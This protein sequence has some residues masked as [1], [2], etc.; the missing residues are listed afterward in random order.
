MLLSKLIPILFFS[1]SGLKNR[2]LSVMKMSESDLNYEKKLILIRHG[3]THMNEYLERPGSRWGDPNFTDIFDAH[4]LDLYKDSMLSEKGIEQA[5][6]LHQFFHSEE[7]KLLLQDV[8][9]VAV[10]PLKRTLQT[11]EIGV[12]PHLINSQ[13]TKP[14][15][16]AQPLATERLYLVSDLGSSIESLRRLFPFVD[17]SSEFERFGDEWWFTVKEEVIERSDEKHKFSSIHVDDYEEWRPCEENQRYSCHGEPDI[18]FYDRMKALYEW[19]ED[20]EEKVIMLV[21]HWGV[22]GHLTDRDFKNCEVHTT[23][24]Q[25]IRTVLNSK[26]D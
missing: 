11:F 17:F 1:K 16:I 9:L 10:S 15:I 5:K 7:G 21:C 6:D 13:K 8:E 2:Q 25:E 3:C 4:E 18:I 24:L 26:C 22:L 19:I 14:K 20:R 23:T 12:I